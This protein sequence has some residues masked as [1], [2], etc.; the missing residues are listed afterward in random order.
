[1]SADSLTIKSRDF[2]ERAKLKQVFALVLAAAGLMTL[3]FTSSYGGQSNFY[4]IQLDEI[5]D[6]D[7]AEINGA[8]SAGFGFGAFFFILAVIFFFTAAI[9]IGPASCGSANEKLMMKTPQEPEAKS[10]V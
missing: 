4:T 2:Y 5:D 1:M 3:G 6:D 10:A 7:V 9:Y 8:L